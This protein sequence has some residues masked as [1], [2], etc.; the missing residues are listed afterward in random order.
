M[1]TTRRLFVGIPLSASFRKRLVEEMRGWPK[2]AILTTT[3]ENLHITIFFLGFVR[4]ENIASMCAKV[5]EVCQN[6]ESFELVFH[7]MQWVENSETPKMIWLVGEASDPLRRLRESIE[8]QFSAFIVEKKVYRP[9]ITLAKIKKSKWLKL[10]DKPLLKEHLLLPEYVDTV[11][12]FESL[13]L[14][15]KRRY[16]PIETFV[17]K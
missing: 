6:M 11:C 9:H 15:G 2:E 13:S 17:L 10:L 1:N 14:D 12:V 3:P 8:K 16:E 7:N 5:G 4:E